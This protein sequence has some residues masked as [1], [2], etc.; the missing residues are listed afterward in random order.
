LKTSRR[1]LRHCAGG[2]QYAQPGADFNINAFT[3]D[4]SIG[5]A[6]AQK[7][8]DLGVSGFILN[9]IPDT[10]VGAFATGLIG[11]A[12]AAG[13]GSGGVRHFW[14]AGGTTPAGAEGS[15]SDLVF[16]IMRIVVKLVPLGALGAMAC[17]I[18]SYGIGSLSRLGELM[19][20]FYTTSALFFCRAGV[21]CGGDGFFHRPVS[22]L[23]QRGTAA[24]VRRQLI[25]NRVAGHD[26]EN[27]RL[28]LSGIHGRSGDSDGLQFQPR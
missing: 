16:G 7:A 6:Y 5:E 21:D 9:M 18:G 27:V 10:L 15:L 14:I 13:V 2:G 26:P 23:Y 19:F 25:E 20:G 12:S 1:W 24:G 4:P 22:D 11:V 3:L 28:G 8:H 17:T